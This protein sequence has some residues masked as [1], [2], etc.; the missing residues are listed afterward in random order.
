MSFAITGRTRLLL[1]FY[2]NA[3]L[4][5]CALALL[6]PALLLCGVIG[7]GWLAITAALYALGWLLG[8]QLW[9]QPEV[10]RSLRESLSAEQ[11]LEQ[12]QE[13]MARVRAQLTDEQNQLLERIRSSI[14][15]ILPLLA[16]RGHEESLFTVRETIVRY[17]PET[18]ANYVA[19]PP[20]FRRTHVVAEGKTARDLLVEQLTVLADT[21]DELAGN[22]GR[23]DAQALLANGQ[24]LRDKF[25]RADFSLETRAGPGAQSA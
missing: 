15:D 11:A 4:L 18:L 3:N 5:G 17:L 23:A 2:G 19:L 12:L 22:V 25:Q 6:G 20:L 1:H 9:R 13:L 24:F 7:P 21:I 14:A 10:E 8:T 16:G